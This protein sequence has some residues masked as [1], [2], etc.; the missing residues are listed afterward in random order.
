[1]KVNPVGKDLSE[2][3]RAYTAGFLDA[4]GAIMATIEKHHEKKFGFRVRI[5][6]KITQKELAVIRWFLQTFRVGYIRKNKTTHEW[7]V[8]DQ[9]IIKTILQT[10]LPYLR[11]KKFQAEKALEIIDVNVITI[12]DLLRVARTADAL[13]RFNV[14][15]KN[16]RKNFVAMIQ[17]SCLP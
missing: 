10:L 16:R 13:S 15:S 3:I 14:R 17:E 7:I 12:H 6:V 8:R 4:D 9:Q 1:M 2:A 11:V 5:M